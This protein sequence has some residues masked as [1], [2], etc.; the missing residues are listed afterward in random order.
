MKLT[1]FEK[2]LLIR[3][4]SDWLYLAEVEFYAG[5]YPNSESTEIVNKYVIDAI[6]RLYN[7][8]L[9]EVGDVLKDHGFEPWLLSIKEIQERI[10]IRWGSLSHTLWPGDVCWFS[11]TEKGKNEAKRIIETGEAPPDILMPDN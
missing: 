1:N 9:W 7:E 3:G 8:G 2:E 11:L 5:K 6:V 10:Q 4:L